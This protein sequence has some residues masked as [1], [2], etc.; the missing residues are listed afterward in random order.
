MITYS[1]SQR[2]EKMTL[3]H[4]ATKHNANIDIFEG[5]LART[6]DINA[7]DRHGRTPLHYAIISQNKIMVSSLLKSGADPN[8]QDEQGRRPVDLLGRNMGVYALLRSYGGGV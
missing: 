4:Y 5:I 6:R 3:L 1:A 7:K 8:L 2:D